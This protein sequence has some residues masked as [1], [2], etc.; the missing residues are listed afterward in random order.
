VFCVNGA[1][2]WWFIFNSSS[3]IRI[4][5]YPTCVLPFLLKAIGVCCVYI[6]PEWL[7]VVCY[8]YIVPKW[9]FVVC[10]VYIVPKWLLL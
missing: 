4:Y 7:H 6:V 5:Y 3:T 10:C 8:V 1:D 2:P 9:L